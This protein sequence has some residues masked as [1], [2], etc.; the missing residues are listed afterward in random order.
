MLVKCIE[1]G[2][3]VSTKS[4][5]CP[6]CGCLGKYNQGI[7]DYSIVFCGQTLDLIK[8]LQL[9]HKN[10][11]QTLHD[12]DAQW[13]VIYLSQTFDLGEHINELFDAVQAKY[14]EIKDLMPPP[15]FLDI[16]ETPSS[17]TPK[18]PTCGST[19]VIRVSI[20]TRML[21]GLVYG[22]LSA[23]GRAQFRCQKCGF[24]W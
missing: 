5:M 11:V 3:L 19:S 16:E 17:G 24:S 15:E 20:G 21:D 14:D 22:H 12:G 6:H 18:C 13:A 10:G 4:L 9:M 2:G 7:I 23:E 1:C 8:P